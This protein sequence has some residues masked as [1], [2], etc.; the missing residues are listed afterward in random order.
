ML[1]A[2]LWVRFRLQR[3]AGAD[4]WLIVASLVIFP[5][6]ELHSFSYDLTAA[7]YRLSCSSSV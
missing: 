6:Q 7:Y 5:L 4:D 3:N 1:F 2:R